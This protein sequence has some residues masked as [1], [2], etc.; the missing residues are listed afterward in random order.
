MF[1]SISVYL[2]LSLSPLSLFLFLSFLLTISLPPLLSLS[3]SLFWPHAT[4]QNTGDLPPPEKEVLHPLPPVDAG[5]DEVPQPDGEMLRLAPLVAVVLV[6]LKEETMRVLQTRP[7][8]HLTME[9]ALCRKGY[10]G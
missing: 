2:S 4:A 7:G 8:E 1:L 5:P 10:C 9:Y 3:L 6:G